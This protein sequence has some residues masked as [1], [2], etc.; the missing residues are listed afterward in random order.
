MP[1]YPNECK[2][3][4]KKSESCKA[5]E[6]NLLCNEGIPQLYLSSEL[7]IHEVVHDCNVFHLYASSSL[8][9]GVCPYCGHVSSQVHSRYSRTIYDLSILG[10]RVV[11]HLDVRKFFCHNDDCCR[12]TFA[13]QPGDEVFRYRRRTCRCERVVARHGIS[14]SSNSACRLLS[15][16]GICVSSSTILLPIEFSKHI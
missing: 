13:E 11:L 5:N 15:D 8:G 16:I 1:K 4:T 3:T 6:I 7:I 2:V 9:Y 10:E 12:K 14:V